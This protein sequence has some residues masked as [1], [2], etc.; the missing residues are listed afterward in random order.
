MTPMSRTEQDD[1]AKCLDFLSGVLSSNKSCLT[2]EFRIFFTVYISRLCVKRC[3][4][5]K[6]LSGIL[7]FLHPLFYNIFDSL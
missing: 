1:F 6:N 7:F 5:G 2:A 4:Y 3:F